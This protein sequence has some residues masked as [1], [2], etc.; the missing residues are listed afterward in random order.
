M[1]CAKSQSSAIIHEIGIGRPD[2]SGNAYNADGFDQDF[3]TSLGSR[4]EMLGG[5]VISV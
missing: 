1:S 4:G 2:K 5:L 3:G